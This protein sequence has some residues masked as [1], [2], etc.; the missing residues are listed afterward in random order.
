ML[1]LTINNYAD[2]HSNKNVAK[3]EPKSDPLVPTQTSDEK[4]K[5]N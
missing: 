2:D 1:Q 4:K 3:S 5:N